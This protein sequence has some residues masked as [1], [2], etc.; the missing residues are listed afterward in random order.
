M[1]IAMLS[2][3]E[4]L[5]IV[6]ALR[7]SQ[8]QRKRHGSLFDRGSADSYYGRTPNPHYGGVGGTSGPRVDVTDPASVAEYMAGYELNEQSGSK[9]EY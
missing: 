6:Q 8:F 3:E 2:T 9:K 4:Q 7:G 5:E 1:Y